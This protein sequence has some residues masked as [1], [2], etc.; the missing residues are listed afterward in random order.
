MDVYRVKLWQAAQTVFGERRETVDVQARS[1]VLAIGKA[2]KHARTNGYNFA[3]SK[4]I[5]VT[6]VELIA[7]DVI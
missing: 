4:P 5:A 6:S 3:K 2:L 1:A 7:S